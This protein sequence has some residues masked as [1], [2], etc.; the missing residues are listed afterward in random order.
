MTLESCRQN[1]RSDPMTA[2]V[3]FILSLFSED[4]TASAV[5]NIIHGA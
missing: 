2:I 5:P 3:N 1:Q 4:Q